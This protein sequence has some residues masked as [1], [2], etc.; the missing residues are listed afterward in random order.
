MGNACAGQALS[1]HIAETTISFPF[2]PVEA[3]GVNS[4]ITGL[5][6]TFA[7]KQ[8][9]ERPKRWQAMEYRY[10]GAG[11]CSQVTE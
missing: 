1:L 3:Q 8:A 9:A 5:L 11:H 7:A 10:K 4:A 2:D 6:Q